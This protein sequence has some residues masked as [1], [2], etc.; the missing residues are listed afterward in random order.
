M[1]SDGSPTDSW[2]PYADELKSKRP[3]NIIGVAVGDAGDVSVFKR[4]TETVLVMKDMGPD[5]F[6]QFFKWV[7]ASI[8]QTSAKCGASPDSAAGGVNLPPPPPQI[9]IVP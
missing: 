4:I 5:A 8:V 9:T 1:F 2:E 3:G 7:S 6:S